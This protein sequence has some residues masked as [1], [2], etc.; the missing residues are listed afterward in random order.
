MAARQ[1]WSRRAGKLE[2]TV[3]VE[4]DG[5]PLALARMVNRGGTERAVREI[6]V[7]DRV[8]DLHESVLAIDDRPSEATIALPDPPRIGQADP[9]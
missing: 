8:L 7:G 4:V 2:Q 3:L 1:R 6:V 5:R 9:L